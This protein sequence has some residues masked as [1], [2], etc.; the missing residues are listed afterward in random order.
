[1]GIHSSPSFMEN[2]RNV[3]LRAKG[4]TTIHH[5]TTPCDTIN[6]ISQT[7]N[8]FLSFFAQRQKREFWR[9]RL[10][11]NGLQN[12]LKALPQ[13]NVSKKQRKFDRSNEKIGRKTTESGRHDERSCNGNLRRMKQFCCQSRVNSVFI[14]A[15]RQKHRRNNKGTLN[16]LIFCYFLD[17]EITKTT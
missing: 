5:K 6:R 7:L 1:M 14:F 2:G 4:F 8:E 17:R 9:F 16:P 3:T 10:I 15:G 13:K 12:K 11:N